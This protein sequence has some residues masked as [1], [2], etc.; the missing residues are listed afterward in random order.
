MQ[1]TL[2]WLKRLPL[3]RATAILAVIAGLL[4]LLAII[5]ISPV[6]MRAAGIFGR[7]AQSI[8]NNPGATAIASFSAVAI[9]WLAIA[10]VIAVQECRPA[11]RR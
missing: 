3:L 7:L 10:L 9:A 2:I 6:P 1:S 4:A 11:K 8:K 5:A